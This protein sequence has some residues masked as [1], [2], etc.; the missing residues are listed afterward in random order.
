MGLLLIQL[1][2]VIKK[3]L[4]TFGLIFQPYRIVSLSTPEAS[5]YLSSD[6]F[7]FIEL[8]LE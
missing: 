8:L 3:D 7:S 5:S 2:I 4:N 1:K 6:R